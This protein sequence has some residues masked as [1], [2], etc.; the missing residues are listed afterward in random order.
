[1]LMPHPTPELSPD[2]HRALGSGLFNRTWD[3]LAIEHRTAAQDDELIDTA[4]ASAW[5][6]CQ[7][8]NPAN[9][10]RGHWL[11]SRV[12]AVLGMGE[13][14]LHHARRAVAIVEAGGAGI[15][16]WD[17]PAA[18]EAMARALAVSG[19]LEGCAT[20]RSRAAAGL[21]RIAEPEDREVIE[22]DLATLP[23]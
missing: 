18:A 17:G 11:C 23:A 16:D 1:M 6:W 22:R 7:V 12:Y 5:H 14:A 2:V 19:D 20:W 15:E 8:G 9:E 13:T 3:L 4:H 21:E 10:A